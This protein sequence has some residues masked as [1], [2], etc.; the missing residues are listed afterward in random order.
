MIHMQNSGEQ[1]KNILKGMYDRIARN[2]IR[3]PL[4]TQ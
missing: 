1:I 4:K 3:A 2:Y